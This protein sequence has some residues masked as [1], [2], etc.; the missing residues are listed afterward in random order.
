[1]GKQ[2]SNKLG[3]GRTF[4]IRKSSRKQIAVNENASPKIREGDGGLMFADKITEESRLQPESGMEPFVL[5]TA[6]V[7]LF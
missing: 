5:W 2:I 7:C 6:A 4:R 3:V 1:M